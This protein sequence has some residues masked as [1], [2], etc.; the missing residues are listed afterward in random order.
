MSASPTPPA[1]A[2]TSAWAPL[3]LAAFRSLWLAVL[4]SNVGT[5]MQAVGGRWPGC[6][7]PTSTTTAL[8]C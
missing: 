7:S 2:V 6:R 3:R 5:W 4:A 8:W 1:D